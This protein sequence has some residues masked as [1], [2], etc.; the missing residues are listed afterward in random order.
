MF[1]DKK[2]SKESVI[3][4]LIVILVSI[5]IG[6]A[7][8]LQSNKVGNPKVYYMTYDVYADSIYEDVCTGVKANSYQ[9]ARE[10][11]LKIEKMRLNAD[12]IIEKKI[13]EE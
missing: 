7:I 1:K 6:L 5:L 8:G 4:T 3:Y 10:K 11:I 12:S 13:M 2:F 9:E